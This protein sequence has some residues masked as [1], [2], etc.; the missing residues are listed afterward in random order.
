MG[1]PKS[2]ERGPEA[3]AEV[4][5][6]S[7][8]AVECVEDIERRRNLVQQKEANFSQWKSGEG[9]VERARKAW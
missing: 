3:S 4:S 7:G 5:P 8:L 9:R 6:S 1:F 2:D